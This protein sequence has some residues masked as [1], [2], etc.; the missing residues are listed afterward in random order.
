MVTFADL[1]VFKAALELIS[2]VYDATN[3]F[4]SSELYGLTSQMRRAAASINRNIAEGQGRLTFG[5]WRQLLSH[6]R[7]SLF[8][9]EADII[10]AH[11]LAYLDPATHDRL[12]SMCS[13][14]AKPLAGLIRFVQE[15]E[16][17]G[18]PRIHSLTVNRQQS[19][20]TV[21]TTLFQQINHHRHFCLNGAAQHQIHRRRRE[22]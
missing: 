9:V 21:S 11:R 16:R 1:D 19:T 5:E 14:V 13:A 17:G 12:R 6:A 8:E 15:Q 18:K 7:G 2:A 3:G 10:T 22:L 4:P 20:V